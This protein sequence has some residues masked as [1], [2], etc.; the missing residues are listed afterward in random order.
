[1]AT[2]TT[3]TYPQYT[4]LALNEGLFDQLMATVKYHLDKEYDG[5]RIRGDAYSKVYLGSM[6][7]VMG[8]T[9]Q[10]LLGVMLIKEQKA[11]LEL[12]NELLE[13]KKE[14]LRFK[15]DFVYPLEVQKLEQE[16]LLIIAQVDKIAQEIL[17]IIQKVK[18]ETANTD[19]SDVTEDSVVGRQVAL[20]RTQ[21]LGFA[22]DIEAKVAKMHND[23]AGIFQTVQEV[24]EAANTNAD[25]IT[26]MMMAL[27]TAQSMKDEAYVDPPLEAEP[28]PPIIIP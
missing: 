22:G 7:A 14:E 26:A 25:T 19:G 28:F 8:N 13:L 21:K 12:E 17:F 18:T 4:N 23:Y 20:L 11:Q 3:A 10:Y 9:T 1:M 27:E 2:N 15:I 24:P 6:E 16:L 5:H